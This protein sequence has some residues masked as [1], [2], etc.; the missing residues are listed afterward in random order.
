M[1]AQANIVVSSDSSCFY[2]CDTPVES[3]AVKW[4]IGIELD[5]H[6]KKRTTHAISIDPERHVHRIPS[7]VVNFLCF[8]DKGDIGSGSKVGKRQQEE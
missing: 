5:V 2:E 6:V 3:G 8:F 1:V 7:G 4:F